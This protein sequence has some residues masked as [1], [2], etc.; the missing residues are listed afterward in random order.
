[1]TTECASEHRQAKASE[2]TFRATMRNV[3]EAEDLADLGIPGG[4]WGTCPSCKSTVM[5]R[6]RAPGDRDE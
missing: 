5:F 4:L 6:R 2:S 1:M 3:S